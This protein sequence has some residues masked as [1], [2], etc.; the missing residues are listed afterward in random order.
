MFPEIFYKDY[1]NALKNY[2]VWQLLGWLDIFKRYRRSKLGQLWIVISTFVVVG[3]MSFIFSNL[4]NSNYFIFLVYLINNL[5][6]W[7]FFKETIEDSSLIFID[8]KSFLFNQKWNHLVMIFRLLARNVII[9][10]HNLILI[11]PINIFF[12]EN[13]TLIGLL[14]FIFH[15]ILILPFFI[16]LSLIIAI[17]STRFRDFRVLITNIMQL[18]FFLT[19]VIY[20]KISF[21]KYNWIFDFNIFAILLEFITNPL[22]NINTSLQLYFII[23]VINI[24]I[25]YVSSLIYEKKYKRINYWI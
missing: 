22:N 25:T 6:L 17:V 24:I 12:N 14:T 18:I 1:F 16:S 21:E 2:K 5:C 19:P 3:S 4:F 15:F 11:I 13:I 23:M 20:Q 7:N 8:N 10:A 9:F